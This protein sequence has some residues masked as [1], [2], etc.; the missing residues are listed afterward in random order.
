M[1]KNYGTI[2]KSAGFGDTVKAV[3]DVDREVIVRMEKKM[4]ARLA[5][6]WGEETGSQHNGKND[7]A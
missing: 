2:S 1:M 6:I 4:Q 5:E 7:G 3:M